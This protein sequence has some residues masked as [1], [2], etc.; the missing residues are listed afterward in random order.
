[1]I[2]GDQ[3]EV[4]ATTIIDYHELSII[5]SLLS[6]AW[7]LLMG[8]PIKSHLINLSRFDQ[9]LTLFEWI[10]TLYIKPPWN[11]RLGYLLP[12]TQYIFI[13]SQVKS[14]LIEL[15]FNWVTSFG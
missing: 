7:L 5:L 11:L 14:N 13:Y 10:L 2:A 12:E 3:T 8:F 6:S 9:D 4:R 1:M 15:L